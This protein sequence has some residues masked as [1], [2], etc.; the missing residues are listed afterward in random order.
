MSYDHSP[1]T[2]RHRGLKFLLAIGYVA[3]A[4]AVLYADSTRPSGYEVSIYAGTPLEVWIGLGVA[5]AVS[6][7]LSFTVRRGLIRTL[8]LALGGLSVVSITALP[9]LRNYFFLGTADALTHLGWVRDISTGALEPAGLFYPGIHTFAVVFAAVT[10]VGL[11]MALM[12]T[13]VSMTA[14]GIVFVPLIVR[15][16]ARGDRAVVVAAFSTFLLFLVHNLGIY[17]HAHAFAQTTFFSSLVLFLAFL[18]LTRGAKWAIGG[19]LALVT[20]AVV[21]YHPQQAGNLILVFGAISLVQLFHRRYRSGHPIADHRPLYAHTGLLVLAF[22]LWIT[23]FE[24]WAFFNLGRM[25]DAITAYIEG[26]PP[27]AGGNFVSQATSLTSIGSGLPEIFVKLFLVAAIFSAFAGTLMAASML[28][29]ADGSR[30]TANAVAVYLGVASLFAV[31]VIVAY[32]AGN[33]AE[34]YFRHIGF[35][36]LVATIVGALALTRWIDRLEAAY[37][38]G[39]VTVAVV[40]GFAILL[41]LS[42][43]TVFPSPFMYKQTQHVTEPQMDGYATVF[44]LNDESATL[45]GIRGGPWRYNDAIY[46][47]SNRR[48]YRAVVPNANLSRLGSHFTGSGYL[49]VTEN[50]W[51]RETEA[52]R[53]LRYTEASLRSLDSQ[54]GVNRVVSNGDLTLY[55]VPEDSE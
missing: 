29:R 39:I 19:L 25:V 18:Y 32:F 54:P 55:Q 49:A 52:Y 42:L 31:P 10:G 43:A 5:L 11:E 38:P 23:R 22:G 9:I 3:L 4:A 41:P 50:D 48:N 7:T 53:G 35:L 21:V 37:N 6:L 14:V 12:V 1:P 2:E 27:T 40:L 36:L 47:V 44:E 13:V 15:T 16:V 17:L 20:I 46:G 30:P 28:G 8:A 45:A 26:R 24:G 34:H 33:I 51:L